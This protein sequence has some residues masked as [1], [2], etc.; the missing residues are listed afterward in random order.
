MYRYTIKMNI[1]YMA[2][3]D[4]LTK[5]NFVN[6]IKFISHFSCSRQKMF[7]VFFLA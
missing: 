3:A 4:F 2:M 6:D 7:L 5:K 1:N